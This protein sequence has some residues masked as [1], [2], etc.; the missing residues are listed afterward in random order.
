MPSKSSVPASMRRRVFREC[1]YTCAV[2]AVTGYEARFPK[3]GYGYYTALPGVYLSIDHIYPKS[4]GGG[5]ER[6]NLRVL[7]TPCNTT[8]GIKHA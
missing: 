5:N 4:K 3:G 6:K 8:K 7:C 1:N 2:C